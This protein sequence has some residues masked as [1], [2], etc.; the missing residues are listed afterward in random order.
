MERQPLAWF[1]ASAIGLMPQA[2]DHSWMTRSKP[3]AFAGAV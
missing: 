1:L 3:F 2:F